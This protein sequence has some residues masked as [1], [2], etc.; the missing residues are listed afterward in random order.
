LT[1]PERLAAACRKMPDRAAWLARLPE[2]LG[3]LERR[4][5]LT[6][7]API[8]CD[9]VS[10]AWVAPVLL[11]NG[12]SAVLKLGMPHMEGEH[13]IQGLRFWDGDPTVR[14]LEASDDLGAMLL[15]RCEPGTALRALPEPEQDLVIAPLLRRLWRPPAAPH[16]FRPLS[17]MMD[18]WSRETRA[19][20]QHWPD[21]GLVREGLRLFK[22]L[23]RA[24]PADVLLATDLHAGNVLRARR[25]RWLVIDPKPFVG[26]PAYDATQ[27][28]L[29]CPGRMHSDPGGTIRR[30][31]DLL[32]VNDERVRLWTFAR[33]AAEPRANWK[34]QRLLDLARELGR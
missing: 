26:D 16:P 30:F 11:A 24:A 10:C 19:R 33:A 34:G 2:A 1:I 23:P 18:F 8:D 27:H 31:S 4:W 9:E 12:T 5:S 32:G 29:N 20:S 7:G 3:G 14:L 28:L 15:E 21:T 13:E 22:E 6:L 17:A 25:E